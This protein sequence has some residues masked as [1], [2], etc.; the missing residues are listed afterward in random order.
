MRQYLF[1][2]LCL[3]LALTSCRKEAPG[4]VHLSGRMDNF[5][6]EIEMG[7]ETPEGYILKD[8]VRFTL[9]GQKQFDVTFEL[10]KPAYFRLDRNT[11]YLTP[12]DDMELFCDM[13]DPEA[14]TFTG[15]GAEACMYL[16]S[17]PFPKA[18]SYLSGSEMI[19]DNPD[20]PE[21]RKRLEQKVSEASATLDKLKGVSK[22]F[23]KLEYGRIQFDAANSLLS[24]PFYAVYLNN[25]P[26]E[27]VQS[28]M[29]SANAY[30]EQDVNQYLQLGA[31]AAY[32]HL[33][34]YRGLSEKCIEV[35]GEENVDQEI[36]DFLETNNLTTSLSQQGPIASVLEEKAET[37]ESV[38]HLVYKELI[39][40]AF[41]KYDFLMPGKPAP[42]LTL[43]TIDENQVM[44][45]DLRGKLVVIDV[46]ATWCGPC[47][48]ESPYFE[49][50]AEKYSSDA[51]E[52]ISI[53]IDSDK[54]AWEKYLD[55]HKKN[56]VQYI[57]NRSVFKEYELIGVPRFMLVDKAG[58]FIEAF[59]PAP[60]AP[61]F[62]KLIS[63][64]I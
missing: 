55:E 15:S 32:L 37:E 29:D 58:N 62:E 35:L 40:R 23:K 24:Y 6:A 28:F 43:N 14:G 31:D 22:P 12:G 11:L 63:E 1:L 26:Q 51:V 50:L 20:F 38:K 52:F 33:D 60:S 16:R 30:F 57:C 48:A 10:E 27:R 18:G 21:V 7:K 36:L 47:K 49:A 45:S 13:N 59:A 25:I 61:A 17:K 56:S 46:W 39:T 53:S 19:K 2:I 34:T 3:S 8:K 5:P 42:E 54:A 44:L 9:D 4:T 64:N 41:K